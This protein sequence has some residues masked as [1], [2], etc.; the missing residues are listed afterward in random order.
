[1]YQWIALSTNTLIPGVVLVYIL[2]IPIG[3]FHL[4][5][6]EKFKWNPTEMTLMH[7]RSISDP[8]IRL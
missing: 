4:A 1:M 6:V 2:N 7:I 8:N 3:A 5:R